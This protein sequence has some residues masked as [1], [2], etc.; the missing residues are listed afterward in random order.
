MLIAIA[1]LFIAA[2]ATLLY[3]VRNAEPMLKN[4]VIQTLSAR[5]N[6]PV[7]LDHLHI[8]IAKGLQIDGEGLRILYLA[9]PTKPDANPIAPSPMLTIRSFQFRSGIRQLLEPTTRVVTVYVQGLQINIPPREHRADLMPDDP[10]KKGQPRI[11]ILVD[12]VVCTDAKIV[13]ETRTPGKDPL[14]FNIASLTL[15]DVGPKRPFTYDAVL[16]NPK[17]VGNIASQGHFGPWQDDNPRDTPIDGRYQFTQADLS[18]IH[19]VYGIL[20]STGRFAGTLGNITAD[21][22]VDVPDFQL[23]VSK[24]PVPVHAGFHATVDGT[25]GNVALDPVDAQILHSTIHAT[26]TVTHA[27]GIPGHTVNLQVESTQARAEDMLRLGVKA[28]PPLLNGA[29]TFHAKLNLPPGPISVSKKVHIQGD[30]TIHGATFTNQQFQQTVDKLSMRAQG[31]PK[32]AND[33]DAVVVPSSMNGA[34]NIQNALVD[35]SDAQYQLPGA[36]VRMQGRSSL[37]GDLL[38]FHGIVQTDATASQMTTGW[39]SF[40]LKPFDGLLSKGKAGVE[41]PFIVTGSHSD[42][43]LSLD[44]QKMTFGHHSEPPPAPPNPPASPK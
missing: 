23:D 40:L 3:Y 4:R 27:S 41:I 29:L 6:S 16:T 1:I 39:K 32:E 42:P 31:R 33:R 34:Y 17:P 30:F 11:S 43:K 8:S 9:G 21:G 18:S 22:S 37:D 35:I 19:G 12:K 36:R 5:F 38:D 2:S 20:A 25:T 26:G 14:V 24:H 15:L 44:L 28:S 13:L 7:E 10:R